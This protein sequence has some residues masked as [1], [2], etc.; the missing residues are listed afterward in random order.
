MLIPASFAL[1]I[2][3]GTASAYWLPESLKCVKTCVVPKNTTGADDTPSIV[4]TVAECGDSSRV[5]FETGFTYNLMTPLQLSSLTNI[6]FVFNANVSLPENITYVESVV[7]N[8]KIYPGRWINFAGTN[9]TLTGSKEPGNGWFI[10]HGELWWPGGA[11]NSGNNARPHFFS[12]KVNYLRARDLKIL[13]PVAWVFSMGGSY[14][15]MTNTLIDARS[16]DGFP[17]NTDGID[18]SASNSLIEGFTIYNG[19]DLINIS[20]PTTNVTVRN[21]YAS[22]GH[23]IAV[24]CSSGI[25]GNYLFENAVVE[26][27]LM[28]ARF[29]GGLGTTCQLNNITWKNFEIRN[30]TYPIHFIE[31]Y[32]DQEKGLSPGANASL[33]AYATNFSW[34]N[35]SGQTGESL[36]DG[37][38]ITDPCWSATLG[39]S[40]RKGLYLLYADADHCKDFH[41]KNISLTGYDGKAAEMECTGLNGV[42]GMGISCTNGT[43]TSE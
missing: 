30:T 28:G 32:V 20:P 21:M 36:S 29:K 6:E 22:G 3:S 31:N 13:N 15:W 8:T 16:D 35:I 17:F 23:G 40:N 10:G 34:E 4:Q 19:D 43:I 33:A 37:S 2:L 42:A 1:V 24:S 27:S 39:D 12:L 26:D 9:V 11:T 18:M 25:G 5:I 7:N 38:C 41:F 14:V